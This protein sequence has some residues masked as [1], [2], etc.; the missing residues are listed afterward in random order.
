MVARDLHDGDIAT[1]PGWNGG[2]PVRITRNGDA[3]RWQDIG[4]HGHAH[5]VQ[6]DDRSE[7][8]VCARRGGR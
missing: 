2:R 4:A 1:C 8:T 7:V 6:P 5:Q 3:V